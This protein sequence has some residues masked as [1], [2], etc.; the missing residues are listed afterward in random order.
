M[1]DTLILAADAYRMTQALRDYADILD[2]VGSGMSERYRADA[3]ILEQ[4][5]LLRRGGLVEVTDFVRDAAHTAV[6]AMM[7][8]AREDADKARA[9]VEEAED[10][11]KRYERLLG[12]FTV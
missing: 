7:L 12:A 3:D 8:N 6:I 5:S 9:A 4:A 11:A 1:T 10:R 2:L